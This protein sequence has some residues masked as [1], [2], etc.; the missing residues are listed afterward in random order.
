MLLPLSQPTPLRRRPVWRRACVRCSP[1]WAV[2]RSVWWSLCGR[3]CSL[4]VPW[5][6]EDCACRMLSP[7]WATGRSRRLWHGCVRVH[8]Y[9]CLRVRVCVCVLCLPP[10]VRRCLC[11]CYCS[12]YCECKGLYVTLCTCVCPMLS[13]CACLMCTPPYLLVSVSGV[14]AWLFQ[15]VSCFLLLPL[16]ASVCPSANFFACWVILFLEST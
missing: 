12:C 6:R 9:L 8:A 10:I 7:A 5:R 15:P 16:S 1:A 2:A 11:N 3:S 13:P 14:S 4:T